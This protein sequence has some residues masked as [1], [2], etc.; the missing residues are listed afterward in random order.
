MGYD[1]LL[2]D[3]T[4]HYSIHLPKVFPTIQFIVSHT[5]PLAHVQGHI[6]I[7]PP[8]NITLHPCTPTLIF[9]PYSQLDHDWLD[10]PIHYII[11]GSIDMDIIDDFIERVLSPFIAP[12]VSVPAITY[13]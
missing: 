7:D 6:Y 1:F 9:T 11:N 4:G 10:T 3:W 8:L 12:D 5:H 13:R 2:R